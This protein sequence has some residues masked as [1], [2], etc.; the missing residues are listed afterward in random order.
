[1]RVLGDVGFLEYE[2]MLYEWPRVHWLTRD[3]MRAV[4]L[5][6]DAAGPKLAELDHDLS[7]VELAHHLAV[8]QPS[9]RVVTEREIRRVEP[10]PAAGPEA[11]VRADVQQFGTGRGTGGRAFPDLVSVGEGGAPVWVHELERSRKPGPRLERVMLAYV[12]AEHITGVVYW[13]VP[14][15]LES[16]QTAADAANAR[17]REAG[18]EPAIVVRKWAPA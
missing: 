11:A 17:A 8:L 4:G 5:T 9:H 15:L 18:R 7:V 10:N 1:M 16:V 2:R 6:G 12:W 3:G 13:T 14:D